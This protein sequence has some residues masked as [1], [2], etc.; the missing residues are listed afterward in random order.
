MLFI[1]WALYKIYLFE[2]IGVEGVCEVHEIF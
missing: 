1:S 2:F